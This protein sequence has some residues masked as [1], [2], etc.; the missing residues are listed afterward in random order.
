[1]RP[2]V[3]IV[4]TLLAALAMGGVLAGAA[5]AQTS[6]EAPEGAIPI[7]EFEGQ[8]YYV[9][10]T[11]LPDGFDQQF[12]EQLT[13]MTDEEREEAL[14][15]QFEQMAANDPNHTGGGSSMTG[16]CGGFAY[17]FDDN[18]VLIDAAMDSATDAPPVSLFG[19]G[20]AFTESNPFKVD[21][22]GTVIYMG[23][24]TTPP[25]NH[26]WSVEI[27]A[28]GQDLTVDSGGHPN[29]GLDDRNFGTVD[30]GQ[31]FPVKLNFTAKIT[32]GM[33]ANGGSFICA[34]SGW[35]EVTGENNIFV[36]VGAA[37][38]IL[39]GG[40]GILFNARPARTWKG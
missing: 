21:N 26:T 25:E 34:G 28:L 36:S 13:Q 7:F 5:A 31:D 15:T 22:N 14:Q 23:F 9:E 4:I 24:T 2:V 33:T 6:G 27:T 16:P 37:I 30:L 38:A 40:A 8:T 32:A 20:Q 29:E 10:A 17:S 39:G 3:R 18:G 11:E 12:I 19:G 35:V 1:M